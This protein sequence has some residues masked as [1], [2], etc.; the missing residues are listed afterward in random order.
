[1]GVCAAVDRVGSATRATSLPW[2]IEASDTS[3]GQLTAPHHR[4]TIESINDPRMMI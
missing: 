3:L 2:C 4:H 1:M